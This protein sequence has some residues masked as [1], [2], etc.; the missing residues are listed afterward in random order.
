V[1]LRTF[2]LKELET[3]RVAQEMLGALTNGRE[4]AQAGGGGGE[5]QRSQILKAPQAA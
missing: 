5:S 2:T 4:S 3:L 1:K